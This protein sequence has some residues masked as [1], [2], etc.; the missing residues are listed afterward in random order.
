MDVKIS[1][2]TNKKPREGAIYEGR[3]LY[4]ANLD[5]KADRADIKKAFSKY[6]KIE[7]IR[8]PTKANGSSKGI[9]YVVFRSKVGF[10][11]RISL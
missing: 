7:S 3:E 1:D 6:G 4:L 9:G 10:P 11:Y 8:I 2:P 5:W